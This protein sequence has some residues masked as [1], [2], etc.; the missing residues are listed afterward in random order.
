MRPKTLA[1][2]ALMMLIAG[3]NDQQRPPNQ[4]QMNG[5]QR[6]A[7]ANAARPPARDKFESSRDAPI[8]AETYF[9]AGQLAEA[10]DALPRAEEQYKKA[11]TLDSRHRPS[12]YRLG[13]MYSRAKRFGDAIAVWNRYVQ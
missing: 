5:Q 10:Q 4:Q 11:L 13:V 8:T 1:L 12:M 7:S 2:Y 6:P 9:A 3:C